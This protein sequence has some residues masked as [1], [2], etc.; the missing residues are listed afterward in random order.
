MRLIIFPHLLQVK[1]ALEMRDL[2]VLGI[3]LSGNPVV[4]E[5]YIL[6]S[7]YSKLFVV[8]KHFLFIYYKEIIIPSSLC[9]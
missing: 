6:A 5:W 9:I 3:D 8:D 2:R 4:G 7:Y 1:L